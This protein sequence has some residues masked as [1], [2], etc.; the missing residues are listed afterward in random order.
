MMRKSVRLSK[1]KKL[2][3]KFSFYVIMYCVMF[4][5]ATDKHFKAHFY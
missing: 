3:T 1:L 4:C 2:M 5:F